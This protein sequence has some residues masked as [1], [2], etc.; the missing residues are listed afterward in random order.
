MRH[1]ERLAMIGE[2]AAG[3]AHEIRNPLA[4]I[5]GSMQMLNRELRLTHDHRDVMDIAIK[6]TERLNAIITDFL[7]YARPKPIDPHPCDLQ[8]L[9]VETIRLIKTSDEYQ[10]TM[11]VTLDP[12]QVNVMADQDQ[13]RQVFWNLARNAIQAMPRGGRLGITTTPLENAVRIIFEDTG[14][15]VPAHVLDRIFD[16]FFTTKSQGS[17]LGLPIVQRIVEEHGGRVTVE[18]QVGTGTRVSLTLP[19]TPVA[20]KR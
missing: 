5:S 12:V 6:E 11:T 4:A 8:T 10:D 18:T 1:Q 15:G 7:Q 16:P 14:E 20:V 13:L 17:G 19:M 3:V 9:L 2:L